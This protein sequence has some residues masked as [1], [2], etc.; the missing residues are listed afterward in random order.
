MHT[1]V[2]SNPDVISYMTLPVLTQVISPWRRASTGCQGC[3]QS[4]FKQRCSLCTHRTLAGKG[5]QHLLIPPPLPR[6]TA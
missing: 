4:I 1:Q 2:R 3:R 6:D 5:C